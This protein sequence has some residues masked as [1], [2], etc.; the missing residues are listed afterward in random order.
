M[1]RPRSRLNW[2]WLLALPA[3]ALAALYAFLSQRPV[4]GGGPVCYPA[5]VLY[6]STASALAT[7]V[8]LVA[9]AVIGLWLPQALGRRRR[10]ALNGLAALA[11]LVAG[12]LACWGALPQTFAPYRHLDR[13][14]VNGQVYQLGLRVTLGG[15]GAYFVLCGCGA[16]GL[17]CECRDLAPTTLEAITVAPKL[18]ADPAGDRLAVQIGGQTVF[19]QELAP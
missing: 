16:S 11:A 19:E 8:L 2:L 5:V 10:A 9:M 7:A 3:L 4:V 15:T 1:T 6:Y 18:V 14:E 17:V 12:G 13:A